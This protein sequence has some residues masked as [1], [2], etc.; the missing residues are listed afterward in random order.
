[1]KTSLLPRFSAFAIRRAVSLLCVLF[2]G[3]ASGMVAAAVTY[4]AA[5]TAVSGT[6]TAGVGANPAWPAHAANDIALLF[7]ESTGA[8]AVSL[9]VANGFTE[10][11]SS[12]QVSGTGANDTRLTV[13]WARATSSAMPAPLIAS[14]SDHFY[15]QIVTF[16]GVI[17]T[18]NPID[19][20][21]GGVKSTASTTVSLPS[22]TT[23]VANAIVV[24][25]VARGNDS[26]AAAF[27]A[28]T[29]ANLT[30]ITEHV[31]AGTANGDGGGIGVWS[32][33]KASA[34]ATG[35]T[36]AT[37]T[38]SINAFVTIALKPQPGPRFQ[39]AGTAVGGTATVSP[40]WPAHAVND[41][42]LLFV[43]SAGGQ[44]IT[45]S[46]PAGFVEVTGSPQATGAGT[47]GTRLAVFWARATSTAMPA[48]TVADP[49]DHVYAQILTFRGVN[50][51]G[52]PWDVSGG[53]IKAAAS[54]TVTLASITTTVADTL[55]V[56]AVSRDTDSAAAAFS[57][58]TNV[59]LAGLAERVD[60][61]TT[62][63]N[64]GGFSVWDGYKASAGATG[65]TT[66][67]VSSSIN[68]YLSLALK[69]QAPTGPPAFVAAGTANT[70]G[71]NWP[72]HSVG[73]V[74]LLFVETA[75]GETPV[76]SDPAGF[77][78][79]AN[80]PQSTGA[81][82]AGTKLSVYWVRA[83]STAMPGPTITGP[84]DHVYA[85]ILTYRGAVTS[86]NPWDV[87]GGGVK[88]AASTAVSVA[89]V[90]T[91]VPNTLV[92]QAVAR[93]TDNAAAAFSAQTNANLT[94][95]TER[96]D[97]GTTTGLG[98]G[99]A[100][101]DGSK[102]TAG[103][104][105][106]T[107][108]TVTSSIN[109]FLTV[110]LK[111]AA[112]LP[113]HYE[114]SLP[115][116]NVACL[117]G[118]VSVKACA[119]SSSPCTN[120]LTSLTGQTANLAATTCT[121]GSTTVTFN[122]SG[123]ASTTLN[124]SAVADGI[125]F[126]VT[127]S[128]ES[129]PTSPTAN[130]RQCC[131][132]GTC[133][134][135]ASCTATNKTAGFIFAAA[136][137]GA[138]A[139]IAPQSAGVTSATYYLRAIQTNT[140][141]HACEP[142][143]VGASSV[144]LGYECN[145]PTTCSGSNLMSIN[146]GSATTIS[147]NNNGAVASYTAVNLNFD[148]NGNAPFTLNFS[149]AGQTRLHA[150]K[151]AGGALLT[152]L[153][154][155]SLAFVTAP[156]DFLV[157]PTGPYAAGGSFSA[158]VT[159]RASGGGTTPNFGL[160]S[161]AETVVLKPV[162]A[163]AASASNSQL[164]G[165][166]GGQ[167][168]S[169]SSGN[170]TLAACTPATSGQVCDSALAWNEVGDLTLAAAVANG[171][172]YLGSG[173]MPWGSAAAGPFRPAYLTTALETAEPCTTF[174]YSSQ[175]FR[176]R[177]KAMSTANAVL[178]SSAAT[179]QNYV[180]SYAKGVTLGADAG[181]ACTPATAGFSNNSLVPADFTAGEATTAPVTNT[182]APLP[183]SFGQSPVAG[184]LAVT[185]CARDADGID[186]HGQT[187]AALTIR[188]GR[189]RL[190][191]AYGSELLPLRLSLRTEYFTGTGWTATADDSCTTIPAG[192]AVASAGI[193][194]NLCFLSSP[195]PAAPTN[196]S[197]LA[198]SPALSLSAGA[199]NYVLFD[200][201]PV[202]QGIADLGINLGSGAADSSCNSTSPAAAPGR[203]PWLQFAWCSGKLDPN[204]RVKYGSPK[205]PYI[206]LRERY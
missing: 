143:L 38:S 141:T 134:V 139:T 190:L 188:N 76:L 89:G 12:P 140:T 206:Y 110:A 64:G 71:L 19:A 75:G 102:V 111:P 178:G 2:L 54:A 93:D 43:E 77:A 67:T 135:S 154:G 126:T 59:N 101:W 181:A 103:I 16:R 65:S 74:A 94:G 15:A 200:K 20:T 108:A 191:G 146:G 147:R 192:A 165:P 148:A 158:K 82:T 133:T 47:A 194:A 24:Q 61:G 27:S 202:Q 25:A 129:T 137:D 9:A 159:A 118:N 88:A 30:G 40:A 36:T 44:A 183:I 58:Q 115:S 163:A 34:G 155:A 46:T 125:N 167:N 112:G 42:A 176:L 145:N 85:R 164:V 175:P 4:Q 121:L 92:V 69:P 23:T 14:P 1:M 91:T 122:A 84:A 184:P 13:F 171:L 132:G 63:G 157:V 60:A 83:T 162:A 116:S 180:G 53:G 81:G 87:T 49:G 193:S 117:A 68:S 198:S 18:G 144:N 95:I 66:V 10:L 31:D 161:T 189:L 166:V 80:S 197:C 96:S 50:T 79:V 26:A 33:V 186:S 152:P 130:A 170:F 90:T 151:A 136:A 173:L 203:L 179:A 199:G 6:G 128:G 169:L 39:A 11:A 73:D 195:P 99:F 182:S 28:Q 153:A 104:T 8:Q 48:P 205:A 131:Q 138:E 127:L 56:Q 107:T 113:H 78:A 109:A 160:E 119:D 177:V 41:V 168:G 174:T 185:V 29:N 62:Q 124:C 32:G 196:A 72:T 142:A 97:A 98:G 21:A 156:Y 123:V 3:L 201:T 105:G 51:T 17:S 37:V 35:T 172:G 7:V 52:D 57:S 5:G 55:V 86:G 120:P 45:L 149:D 114:L 22:V 204:A 100:V 70:A 187:Q 150:A 106:N